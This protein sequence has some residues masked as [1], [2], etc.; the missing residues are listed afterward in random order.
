VRSWSQ[1][2]DASPFALVQPVDD[3][4]ALELTDGSF[5]SD[6]GLPSEALRN[7]N[8]NH[9]LLGKDAY[10]LADGGVSAWLADLGERDRLLPK[11][12]Q[13]RAKGLFSEIIE[14]PTRRDGSRTLEVLRKEYGANFPK[15]FRS[16]TAT[17]G[18]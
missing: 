16:S 9:R 18:S 11:R 14:A 3:P 7:G 10:A 4:G 2:P 15:R 6:V 17:G 12:L 1:L 8:V 5:D 13:P